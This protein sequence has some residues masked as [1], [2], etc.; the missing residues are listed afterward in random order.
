MPDTHTHAHT[1]LPALVASLQSHGSDTIHADAIRRRRVPRAILDLPSLP[2]LLPPHLLLRLLLLH[3]PTPHLTPP[4]HPRLDHAHPRA[5][6]AAHDGE[7]AVPRVTYDD[8]VSEWGRYGEC[9]D[10]GERGGP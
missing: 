2:T 5:D 1:A 6:P 3:I 4:P 10:G 7:W 9:E 8:A